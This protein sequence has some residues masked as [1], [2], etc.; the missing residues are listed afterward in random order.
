MV[1]CSRLSLSLWCAL[2]VTSAP[3]ERLG[4]VDLGILAESTPLVWQNELWL[5]ECIQGGRYYGRINSSSYPNAPQPSGYLRFTNPSTGVRSAPFGYGYGLGNALVVADPD[6]GHERL[7][8]FATAVPWGISGNNTVVS[9]FWSDDMVGWH[10]KLA[11]RTDIPHLFPRNASEIQRKLWNTSVRR[12]PPGAAISKGAGA[13]AT[14]A[15][16]Y[17]FN[18][19][20]GGGWQT[21]FAFT[22]DADLR[23]ARWSAVPR[24][25]TPAADAWGAR[26]HAN[27]TLRWYDGWWYVLSTRGDG[28]TMVQEIWRARDISAFEW[29]AP[30]GWRADNIT[31]AAFLAPSRLDQ[32]PVAAPWHPDTRPTVAGN[33]SAIAEAQNDNV[34]DLDL[35]T[36]VTKAGNGS[37]WCWLRSKNCPLKIAS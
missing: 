12:V 20:A 15:M 21:G 4:V 24:P 37:A 29:Q 16:A 32:Q 19:P 5:F 34:S 1:A 2:L 23:A 3:I 33:A 7:F 17:E 28:T 8:V 31:A 25:A 14:F 30:P 10:S 9:V 35:C 11:L 22:R 27:P 36:V 6:T 26:S 18:D 13:G